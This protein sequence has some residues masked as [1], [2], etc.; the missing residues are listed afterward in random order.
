MKSDIIS[1]TADSISSGG[2]VTGD[3]T[4]E[5]DFVVEGG[6]SLTVDA[7]VVGD[8]LISKTKDTDLSLQLAIT[9]DEDTAGVSTLL[10]SK[11]SASGS[12]GIVDDADVLGAIKFGGYDGNSYENNAKIDAVVNGTPSDNSMPIDMRFYTSLTAAPVLAMTIDKNQNVG[13]GKSSSLAR[14]LH[15]SGGTANSG[16][17]LLEADEDD[18]ASTKDVFI[19]FFL[20]GAEKAQIGV[21][22]G[23]SDKLKF[24]TGANGFTDARMTIDSTG[25]VGIGTD[26]PSASL[27]INSDIFRLRTSKTPSSA[28]DTG[29]AGDICWDSGYIYVCIATNSWKRVAIASW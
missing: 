21:D 13:I 8:V 27:D 26:S 14:L 1:T 29:N 24:S 19:E 17:I 7:A 25:Y 10:L 12:G 6:G 3:L 28:T 18:D 22:N 11:K 23:D 20:G 5:G 2:T 9:T 4:V 16:A 15:I